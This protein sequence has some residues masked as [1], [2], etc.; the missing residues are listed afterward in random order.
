MNTYPAR[1]ATNGNQLGPTAPLVV[2]G[3]AERS[4]G[5]G[6]PPRPEVGPRVELSA[7][8][9]EI[10]I[11]WLRTD[12]KAAVAEELFLTP[13][14]VRTYLQRVRAKYARAGRP[15]RTKAALAARAIQDGYIGL[16]DL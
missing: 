15:A 11:A 2:C 6:D 14:T 7:R 3:R 10:L 8:E 13:S 12:S 1:T 9:L 16:N 4:I 5:K